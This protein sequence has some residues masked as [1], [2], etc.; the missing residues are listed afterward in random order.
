MTQLSRE[1]GGLWAW[2][3]VAGGFL[4]L[5]CSF[6]QLN[7]FGTFQAWYAQHQLSH[8]PP[9]T[10]AWI[11]S[12][13]L[14]VF[15]FSGTFV[16]HAFDTYGPR[17]ILAAGSFVMVFALMMTS[18]CTRYYQFMLA[19]G[20]LFSIGVAMLFY[21]SLASVATHF[22][23]RRATAIGLASAGSGVG[24]TVFPIIFPRLFALVGFAWAV[25]I[26]GFISLACC[27]L[28]LPMVTRHP[29]AI[30]ARRRSG[31]GWVDVGAVK[32]V[33]FVLLAVGCAFVCFGLFIPYFFITSYTQAIARVQHHD[34]PH[35]P[36]SGSFSTSLAILNA[37]SVLGR[38]LPP[39]IA[40]RIGPY[41]TLV[42]SVTLAG[43]FC[44]ALW[45]P[46]G[47][48]TMHARDVLDA[49]VARSLEGTTGT[50]ARLVIA[51]A[52]LYGFAS[53]AAIA[54]ITPCVAR[55][56]D[57]RRIGARVGMLY[58]VVSI[59]SLFGGPAAGALIGLAG[60]SYTGAIALA[61]A[62]L[63]VGAVFV[64]WARFSV[65]SRPCAKV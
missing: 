24:G 19:Q 42:P 44:V 11:G 25:R 21:C 56:S 30:G 7:A 54:M 29:S 40:D 57:V 8:L 53:G 65:D 6:G 31:M 2:L 59:P 3:S 34:L 20:A 4:A 49:L 43:L 5:F 28:T 39:L 38:T 48:G 13:Q 47:P 45:L 41:N 55:I 61:G 12:V 33:R 16:G 58:T 18:L 46:A 1:D 35:P 14:W 10:I 64:A 37:A 15:F 50:P 62:T 23:K 27:A 9:S 26:V 32:D 60:G 17:Y 22:Q 63:L 36:G 52:A 51:F